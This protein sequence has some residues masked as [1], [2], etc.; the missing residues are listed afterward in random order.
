MKTKRLTHMCY[1]LCAGFA[2]AF[3]VI[4]GGI[5]ADTLP[6]GFGF[7]LACASLFGASHFAH[8]GYNNNY[9]GE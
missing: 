9:K 1:A 4:L 8:L 5:E 7:A 2:V 6:L 3:A